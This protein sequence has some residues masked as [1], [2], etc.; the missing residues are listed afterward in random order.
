MRYLERL[1]VAIAGELDVTDQ[2]PVVGVADY[3]EYGQELLRGH[4]VAYGAGKLVHVG[5]AGEI[6]FTNL[7]FGIGILRKCFAQL[8][9][10]GIVV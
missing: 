4:F 7:G 3:A 5:E 10:V 1:F 6:E 8:F 9:R 2:V